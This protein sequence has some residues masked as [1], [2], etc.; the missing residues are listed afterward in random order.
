M[1]ARETDLISGDTESAMQT[2]IDALADTVYVDKPLPIKVEKSTDGDFELNF[3]NITFDD[4]CSMHVQYMGGTGNTLTIV[5]NNGSNCDLTKCSTPYGGTIV[6]VNPVKLT[7]TGVEN[8]TEIRVLRAGTSTDADSTG[9]SEYV[10]NVT[11]NEHIYEYLYPPNGYT[12]VDIA[13]VKPGYQWKFIEGLTLGETDVTLPIQQRI[14][15][16]YID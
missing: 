2:S 5:N 14:D 8:D 1:G 16:N 15:R 6:V 13:L 10:F 12:Q 9:S 7:L 11:G 3:D 4:R